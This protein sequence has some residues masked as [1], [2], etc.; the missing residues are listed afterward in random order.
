MT[1]AIAQADLDDLRDR[2]GRDRLPDAI[3][4]TGFPSSF[5]AVQGEKW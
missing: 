4:G 5:S 3:P 1:N 2:L